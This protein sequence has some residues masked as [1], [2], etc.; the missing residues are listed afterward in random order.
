[1][2]A[3]TFQ[4]PESDFQSEPTANL[5]LPESDATGF[6]TP[7]I[8]TPSNTEADLAAS[9]PS[10]SAGFNASGSGASLS[11]AAAVTAAA[12]ADSADAGAALAATGMGGFPEPNL[13]TLTNEAA[14]ASGTG[15]TA[16]D[17]ALGIPVDAQTA[18]VFPEDASMNTQAEPLSD[19]GQPSQIGGLAPANTLR[20]AAPAQN[21]LRSSSPET[22]FAAGAAA[23]PLAD[24]NMMPAEPA[25][26]PNQAELPSG[27]S[28]FAGQ[29][30]SGGNASAAVVDSGASVMAASSVPA[31]AIPAPAT[32]QNGSA[33]TADYSSNPVNMVPPNTAMALTPNATTD[34]PGERRL[35]GAKHPVSSFRN[36][37]LPR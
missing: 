18:N 24:P 7:T 4:T 8:D 29:S 33:P 22:T 32:F 28:T 11:A 2:G 1:M 15:A 21:Q 9:S 36:V 16:A 3:G 30:F 5:A 14:I 6:A 34:A 35:E 10:L 37:L 26:F 17:A 23:A 12:L 19:A 13:S 25:G 20:G 27:A 31:A